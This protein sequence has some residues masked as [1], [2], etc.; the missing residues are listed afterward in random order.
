[1]STGTSATPIAVGHPQLRSWGPPL[2]ARD[3]SRRAHDEG[4][5]LLW[6]EAR[7]RENGARGLPPEVDLH[8]P[9]YEGGAQAWRSERFPRPALTHY[10]DSQEW[11][12]RRRGGGG[13]GP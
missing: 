7:A 3:L 6:L 5:L 4:H 12:G 8:S 11:R 13:G 1:M 2:M 9:T 10:L